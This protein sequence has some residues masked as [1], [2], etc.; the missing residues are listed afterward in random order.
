MGSIRLKTSVPR[1]TWRR[2]DRVNRYSH[3]EQGTNLYASV[4]ELSDWRDA[5]TQ[6][7]IAGWTVTDPR[8]TLC[9]EVH[10]LGFKMN[11]VR[12]DGVGAQQSER[13][14]NIRVRST[15]RK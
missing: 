14:I 11:S 4:Q 1:P 2:R 6:I 10:F 5:A 9:N 12:Q 13:I 15:F 8:F 7:E 3:E